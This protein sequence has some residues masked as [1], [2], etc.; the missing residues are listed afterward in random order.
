MLARKSL[1]KYEADL[2]SLSGRLTGDSRLTPLL[3]AGRWDDA[4]HLLAPKL[5][6]LAVDFLQVYQRE[7]DS[8]ALRS[9]VASATASAPGAF[10]PELIRRSL[11]SGD[12]IRSEAGYV[13]LPFAEE[14]AEGI[15]VVAGYWLGEDFFTNLGEVTEGLFRH[16]QLEIYKRVAKQSVWVSAAILFGAAALVSLLAAAL[17]ARQLSKPILGLTQGMKRVALGELDEKVNV[18]AGGEVGY[19]V[20]SFNRMTDDLRLYKEQLARAE[21][22]AA[23]QDVA[24]YVAHEIRNPLTPIKVSLHRLRSSLEDLEEGERS[25][26][27]ESLDSILGEVNSLERLAT[28]FSEFAKLPEPVL[29]PVDVNRIL[30]ELAEL[31]QSES[32]KITLALDASLPL[33]YA[34]AQQIRMAFTNVMKNAAEAMQEGG[35]L[36]VSSALGPVPGAQVSARGAGVPAGTGGVS[37]RGAGVPAR[38]TGVPG[39]GAEVRFVEVRFRDTGCGIPQELIEKVTTP[40]VTTKKGGT[41]LGL[42]VVSKII[43]QHGGRVF[44]ESRENEGTLV[45][46]L[47]P[48]QLP[49]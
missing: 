8:W 32:I 15:L 44:I 24:R 34:D 49:T 39:R 19:L 38:G 29:A 2:R 1:S 31:H 6:T 10:S 36:E 42:A 41:G 45:R 20:D 30:K 22:V 17:I 40:H 25:R 7:E 47:L 35:F 16:G 33:V 23:W 26:F 3:K 11:E 46:M 27:S 9:E 5:Q 14:D 13:A 18:K 48:I 37:A 12:A 43:S 28:S 21:R 4:E